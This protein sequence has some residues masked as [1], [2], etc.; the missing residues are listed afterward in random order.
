MTLGRRAVLTGLGGALAGGL[1]T[2]LC[3]EGAPPRPRVSLVDVGGRPEAADAAPFFEAALA[4]LPRRGGAV[5][6][7]PAGTWR[8]AAGEGV[9]VSVEGFEDLA[10]EGDGARLVFAGLRRPFA[11]SGCRAPAVRGLALDWERPPF[12][13]GEVVA[14]GDGGR[15]AEVRV[16]PQFPVDGS[17]PVAALGTYDRGT[18]LVAR[19][20]VDAYGA[21]ERVA[22]AGAQRLALEFNRPLPLRPGD[23]VVLR[24]ALYAASAL[25]FARCARPVVEDVTVHTAPGMAV[26][27]A[28]CEG[29]TV[30]RLQIAPPA[31]SGRL[32][33]TV[34]DG[35]HLRACGGV[36]LVEDCAME[37]MGD[38]GV[39]V[40]GTYLRIAR[41][42]D[43]RTVAVTA[44]PGALAGAS[45]P[46]S[47]VDSDTLETRGEA[48][49]AAVEAQ[50]GALVLHLGRD[51]PAGVR[52]G[53]YVLDAGAGAQARIVSCRFP[54]NRARGVLVHSD[55]TVEGCTFSG[56]S[57]EAVLLLP[58]ARFMEGPA[59][60]RVLIRDNEI[61]GVLRLGGRP[62]GGPRGAIR[63]DAVP[64]GTGP[65]ALVNHDIAVT[66]NQ[67]A[68]P[69]GAALVARC[70]AG[71]LVDGNRIERPAGPAIGLDRV[72]GVRILGNTCAP[73][74]AV[75][76]APGGDRAEV[77][78][79]GNAGLTGP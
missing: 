9:A 33:T 57:L 78:L 73:A 44:P 53:D 18:G 27:A 7:V 77:T 28:H 35:V 25:S 58:D 62:G 46:V 29:A 66:G 22:L 72:K 38:D 6:H 17:E 54:G 63:V 23:T 45:G 71:L 24:H 11:F 65:A 69:G 60:E 15:A 4:R 41:L 56:Q 3:A 51:L 50:G 30:R 20:G 8:F 10:I 42:L 39:N 43:A 26:F 36:L 47:V 79:A 59:A 14:V 40:H 67:V 5:L 32:M 19:G 2:S 12:S 70:C 37:G 48:E 68:D 55:A 49:V 76:L 61:A 16:D 1:P 13:Q 34:A 31:G 75:A 74:A 21:V 64:G 52:V